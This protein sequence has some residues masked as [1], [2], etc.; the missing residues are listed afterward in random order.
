MIKFLVGAIALV[1]VHRW[2]LLFVVR[3]NRG[4]IYEAFDTRA[5][6]LAVGC[7]LAIL[8][9]EG[10]FPLFFNWICARRWLCLAGILLL[11]VSAA[12]EIRY[13]RWY[14]DA[15]GMGLNSLIV[16]ICLPQLIS[17]CKSAPMSWLNW[18]WMRRLGVLSYSMYLYQQALVSPV[19]KITAGRPVSVGL[20][21]TFGLVVLCAEASY[22]FVERPCLKL[23]DRFAS[24]VPVPPSAPDEELSAVSGWTTSPEPSAAA[25]AS[26][27]SFTLP[28]P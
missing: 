7:L 8:L 19:K 2:F 27:D 5:D 22:R 9:W 28:R 14:R 20:F 18:T 6:S 3:V 13:G 10:K 12:L 17:F 24:D 26:V 16:A 4:Y 1:W 21:V 11:V 25:S 15:V 23:K